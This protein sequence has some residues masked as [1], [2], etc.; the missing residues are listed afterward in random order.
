MK[1][2]SKNEI[3]QV[4]GSKMAI[5]PCY[6]YIECSYNTPLP[7]LMAG[8]SGFCPQSETLTDT[9]FYKKLDVESSKPEIKSITFLVNICGINQNS[10]R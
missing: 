6:M 7:M 4:N 8:F 5:N 1:S 9:S 10:K 3:H 2:L